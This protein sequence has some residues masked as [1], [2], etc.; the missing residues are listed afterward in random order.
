MR[1][2]KGPSYGECTFDNSS[3]SL[4][5]LAVFVL[6]L[7]F[8]LAESRKSLFNQSDLREGGISLPQVKA[9]ADLA[10]PLP[11]VVSGT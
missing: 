6:N 3:G 9:L 1:D 2:T 10:L 11:V 8:R 5:R 7:S 4:F